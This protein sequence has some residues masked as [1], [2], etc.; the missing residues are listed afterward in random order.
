MFT[1]NLNELPLHTTWAENAPQQRAHSTFP[2][3]G[4]GA[5]ENT[6]VVYVELDPAEE[7]GTHTD[8]AEEIL[9]ILAGRVEVIVGGEK[10]IVE[11]PGLAIVPTLVPHNLRNVGSERVKF[12]G[13][14]PSQYL[15]AT[16]E[17]KWLPDNTYV[18][19]TEQMLLAAQQ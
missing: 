19:D 10:A 4:S 3:L 13:V 11:A 1:A 14:F 15:V 18:I 5:N 16:F 12:A 17:N 7:L 9:V 8:S 2:L 6:S